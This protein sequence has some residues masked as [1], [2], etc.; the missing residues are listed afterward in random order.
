[1][2]NSALYQVL[3]LPPCSMMISVPIDGVIGSAALQQQARTMGMSGTIFPSEHS[4][5]PNLV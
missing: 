1:M 5:T 3:D 4:L 2:S